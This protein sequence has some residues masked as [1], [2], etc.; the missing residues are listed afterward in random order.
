MPKFV[1][2]VT[3][4][5]YSFVGPKL[6]WARGKISLLDGAC[7]KLETIVTPVIT[8]TD[9]CIDTTLDAVTTRV[10]AVRTSVANRVAPVQA[11][12]G[13]VQGALVVRSL[14]FVNSSESFIDRLLPLPSNALKNQAEQKD[15]AKSE[16]VYRVARL[17]FAVPLRVTM[18][19]YVKANGAVETVLLSG[20]Q[21][22]GL[23]LDKQNQFAQQVMQRAKPLTDKV[24]S[25]TNPAVKRARAGKDSAIQKLADGRQMVVVKVNNVVIRLHLVEAKDWSFEK[26]SNLKSGTLNVVM[27]VVRTAHGT[28]TRVIGQ[29]RATTLFTKLHFPIEVEQ[30]QAVN[31]Q[32]PAEQQQVVRIQKPVSTRALEAQIKAPLL[33]QERKATTEQDAQLDGAIA[34]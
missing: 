11:K 21:V 34:G 19:M 15:K 16:L 14:E 6:D 7:G 24:V 4:K 31:I 8:T 22:A 33:T 25:L 12:I 1:Q 26:A 30:Q 18:I 17:P 9:K 27:A 32:K 10:S 13:E 29:Q 2:Q 5:S 20:R 28:T 3:G 23:A